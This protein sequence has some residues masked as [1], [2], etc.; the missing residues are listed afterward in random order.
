LVNELPNGQ[1]SKQVCEN[2]CIRPEVVKTLNPATLL[3]VDSGPLEHDCSEVMDDMFSSQP[4]LPDQPL[5]HLDI[6]YFRDGSNFV[7]E[8]T[9]F[10]GYALVTLDAV[11]KHNHCQSGPLHNRQSSLSHVGTPAHCR[12]VS[13]YL[14]RI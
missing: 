10:A 11:M 12:C 5:S 3:P 4:E 2:L 9:R 7:W 1:I 6:E 8:G 14:Y 13:I